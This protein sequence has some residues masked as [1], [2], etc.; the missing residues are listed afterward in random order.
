MS[1]RNP[2]SN[3]C[4]QG[5]GDESGTNKHGWATFLLSYRFT[6]QKQREG[7]W[8]RSYPM[9]QHHQRRKPRRVSQFSCRFFFRFV[10]R[11]SERVRECEDDEERLIMDLFLY[12]YL[13]FVS[14]ESWLNRLPDGGR[15]FP[16][17][18]MLT[19][20]SFL[21][22]HPPM[23]CYSTRH[24]ATYTIYRRRFLGFEKIKALKGKI[25]KKKIF[26]VRGDLILHFSW[27][28]RKFTAE[29]YVTDHG[30]VFDLISLHQYFHRKPGLRL[31]QFV[32]ISSAI[33]K[34]LFLEFLRHLAGN[35]G[36]MITGSCRNK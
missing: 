13:I 30:R 11:K 24:F 3:E 19:V 15:E 22:M 36:T 8:Q 4:Q 25:R 29:L 7:E 33:T 18:L 9:D 31:K 34:F 32:L 12:R 14:V 2:T 5:S 28:N 23:I 27:F 17:S 21:D 35:T 26:F 10:R 16:F 6:E 20:S 1:K